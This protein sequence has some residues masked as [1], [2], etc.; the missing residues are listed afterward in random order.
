MAEPRVQPGMVGGERRLHWR[1]PFCGERTFHNN[2]SDRKISIIDRAALN[3]VASV[4]VPKIH[5]G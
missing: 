2:G 3:R 1:R 5:H 4:R